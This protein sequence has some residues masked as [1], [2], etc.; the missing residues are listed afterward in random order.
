MNKLEVII[1]KLFEEKN[2]KHMKTILNDS[3][4][5]DIAEVMENLESDQLFLTFRL[6]NKNE[7]TDVFSELSSEK[8]AL[9]IDKFTDVEL[10]HIIND[11]YIDDAVDLIEELPS[12]VVHRILL[13]SSKETRLLINQYLQY[14]QN[15][16]GS[17]MTAEFIKL[18]KE[19]DVLQAL[20]EIKKQANNSASLDT[21]YVCDETNHLLGSINIKEILTAKN[22]EKITNLME[23]NP[24]FSYTN[25]DQEEAIELFKK[26]DLACLPVVD[27][28]KRLV[29]IV[30]FD[31]VFDVINEETTEDFEKMA[32]I[33]P[34]EKP[35]LKTK[36]WK[37]ASNRVIWLAV[38]MLSDTIA[39]TILRNYEEAFRSWPILV[40]FIPMLIDTGGNAGSQS[41]TMIIRG[42]AL[43]E[44]NLK[45][46][47]KVMFK[48]FQVGIMAGLILA[49]INLVRL[50]L[51][52]PSQ[53]PVIM[54]VVLSVF[55]IT[56]LSK[57]IGAI[58]PII[59]KSL[60]MDPAIMAAPLI[61]TIIDALG[62][63]LYFQI[64][65]RLLSL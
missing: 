18:N 43:G 51:M 50:S 64:A 55:A 45:D 34:S 30:T 62:L 7:A 28:E 1:N 42:L 22:E 41:S 59:A 57:I 44:I 9:L 40:S 36:A 35:Y 10:R 26:Y 17:I 27:N 48:E 25:T 46:T 4:A 6:L 47:F 11:L 19:N 63:I 60:K 14:P 53:T 12:N 21:F 31:D 33:K 52:Y 16:A 65:T 61:T 20:Q 38:L 58:L 8:Q 24:H 23:D 3:N 37:L 39:G 49:L 13:N 56:I 29:G 54:S 2:F 32:A 5:I 15:S